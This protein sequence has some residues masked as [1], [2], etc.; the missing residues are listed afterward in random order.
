MK[1]FA[2]IL[3]AAWLL[4]TAAGVSAAKDGWNRVESKN[5]ILVGNASAGE[6]KDVAAEMEQ[7]RLSLTTI[8]PGLR[9]ETSVPTR[10]YVFN[11]DDDFKPFKPM[12]KGKTNENVSAVFVPTANQNYIALS[13]DDRFLEPL[14]PV[15]HEYEH[16]I[17][18]LN[19]NNIPLWLD[20][21]LAE[22]YSTFSS[23]DDGQKALI[24]RPIVE[25]ISTLRNAQLLP[26]AKLFGVNH[27]SPD[28]NESRKA[29]IFYAESWALVHYLIFVDAQKGTNQ[30]AQFIDALGSELTVEEAFQI[31]FKR[32]YREVE[33]EMRKYVGKF[34]F[35]VLNVTTKEKT[36]VD[37]NV[38]IVSKATEAETEFYQG[39]LDLQLNRLDDAEKH[40]SK[41]LTIEP[42]LAVAHL[43]MG[44]LRW[45][46]KR[47]DDAK[48]EY[49]AAI[50]SDPSNYLG[51]YYRAIFLASE[52][53]KGE[54]IMAY[55]KAIELQPNAASVHAGLGFYYVQ[56]GLDPV[57]IPSFA[58]SL[59]IDNRNA[60]V[61][62]ATAYAH[63]RLA[64]TATS[65]LAARQYLKL[66][67][68]GDDHSAYMVLVAVL[69]YRATG[70]IP[71]ANSMLLAA[72]KRLSS[73]DWP[74]PVFQYLRKEVTA[75]QLL[76][77]ATDNDKMTEAR[78][79]IGFDLSYAGKKVEARPYL[80]W[81]VT[82][83][84]KRFEEYLLAQA[85]LKRLV[86]KL[87]TI[88]P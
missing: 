27:Q 6:L 49:Q 26:L 70:Q 18:H 75:D 28:Y 58:A 4:L 62:R 72:Q 79:Y 3:I 86:V 32:D 66:R 63:W 30:F 80:E 34:A 24:G 50:E 41:A 81:V 1:K 17:I 46:Q 61:Y 12:Y 48:L 78:A 37:K 31:A 59:K 88:A 14:R 23:K 16:F 74:A 67:G 87:E 10:I 84:N 60:N 77:L 13:S 71:E 35:P 64:R 73:A 2:L 42:K 39:D 56:L 44:M 9:V 22:F 29:G 7:F 83:G 45:R 5:F 68:W 76:A 65:A 54:A 15:F 33:D 21:G 20:E 82:N 43:S 55:R 38:M 19:L 36:V 57:A 85:E 51:Y 40:L 69:G 47:I 8:F 53:S 11:T 52:G 25:H